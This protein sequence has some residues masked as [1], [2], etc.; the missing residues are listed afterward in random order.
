[1]FVNAPLQMSPFWSAW[2]PA[3]PDEQ[4]APKENDREDTVH[5]AACM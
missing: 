4:I 2:L 3:P 5:S 1:M